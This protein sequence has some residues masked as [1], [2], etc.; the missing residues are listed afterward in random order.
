MA[1]KV[2]TIDVKADS[3]APPQAIWDL[4]AD[5]ETWSSWGAFDESF[6]ERPAQSTDPRGVGAIRR[7]RT[8]R[9][10]NQEEVVRFDPPRAFS[11]EVR[12]SDVP[13]RDYHADV[14]LSERPGGGTTISWRSTFRPRW[15]GLGGLVERRLGAFIA[16]SA[17][18]LARAA[19][20]QPER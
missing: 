11:Y 17:E 13:V 8:G 4:V 16:D 14:E 7:F 19:E 10:R 20:A 5:V 6:L 15:P 1:L 9:I 2:R 18:R 12:K 3:E